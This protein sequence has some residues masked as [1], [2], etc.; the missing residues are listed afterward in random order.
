[1]ITYTNAAVGCTQTDKQMELKKVANFPYPYFQ[2][3]SADSTDID[4]I[5]AI[6]PQDMPKTQEQRKE[7]VKSLL[8]RYKLNWNATL[9]VFDKGIM[10]DTIYTK[11]WIDSLNNAFFETHK[12]HTQYFEI[13]VKQK[14]KRNYTLAIYKAART[15][16]TF[17]TRTEYRTTIKPI[18]KGIHPFQYKLEALHKIDFTQIETFNQPNATATD[19]WK[20]IAFYLGQNMSLIT[21]HIEIY[22]K[23]DLIKHHKKLAP[24]IKRLPLT[25]QDKTNL[26]ALKKEW[27]LAIQQVGTFTSNGHFLTCGAET[28]DMKNERF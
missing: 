22:T 12:N 13:P 14:V 1:M 6:P 16:L 9:A 20:I 5:I 24:F 27:L 25:I 15:I 4:V 21:Q 10:V 28:I 3:G 8:L 18:L 2:Y 26:M 11:A 19:I 23:S 17:L 7:F